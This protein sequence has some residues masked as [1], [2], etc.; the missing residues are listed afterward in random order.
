MDRRGK[1]RPHNE[2]L[3]TEKDAVWQHIESFRQL[4]HTTLAKIQT[5]NTWSAIFLLG[6]CMICIELVA[7]KSTKKWALKKYI[8]KYFVMNTTYHFTDQRKTSVLLVTN[9][10]RK[11]NR[12][13]LMS[14]QN[15]HIRN[16]KDDNCKGV[17]KTGHH[18]IAEILQKLALN[19]NIKINHLS[20]SS[21]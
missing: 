9:T 2:T 12:G 21:K 3:D 8:D 5:R 17:K 11:K 10:N 18:D 1:H 20:R 13:T 16:I 15:T 14:Q 7:W 4:N 6:K 19:T